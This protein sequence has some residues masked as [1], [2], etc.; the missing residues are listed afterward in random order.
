MTASIDGWGFERE[1]YDFDEGRFEK[2]TGHFTQLVWRNTTDVGC[3][4]NECGEGKGWLVF[5]EYWPRG[6]IVGLFTEQ[7][8]SQVDGENDDD[9]GVPV[10][11]VPDDSGAA[12]RLGVAKACVYH[13]SFVWNVIANDLLK[14]RPH[15]DGHSGWQLVVAITRIVPDLIYDLSLQ[16]SLTLISSFWTFLMF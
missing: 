6:N 1:D 12:G 10:E 4:A 2:E 16:D 3:A 14:A 11:G 9:G 5:C 8:L 7:V 13:I 15:C